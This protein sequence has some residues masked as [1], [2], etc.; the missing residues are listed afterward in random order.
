MLSKFIYNIVN[1]VQLV[2][3]RINGASIGSNVKL[4][5]NL[6]LKSGYSNGKKGKLILENKAELEH[7]VLMHLY[8]GILKIGENTFIGPYTCIYAH[9][10][11]SI[12]KNVLIAMQT[13]I[14]SSN[15]T[16]GNRNDNIRDLPDKLMPVSICDNVWIGAGCRILGGITIG[17]GA[18][19]GAGSVVTKDIPPF[20]IAVG[21]PAV[22]IKYRT[23]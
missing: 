4:Q 16:M 14:V 2:Y 7:G 12:G 22:V 21:N 11:I 18:V 3:L 1:T 15:H 10:N 9:G 5:S 6:V 23:Y 20:G 19:V 17:E 13:T 8:G